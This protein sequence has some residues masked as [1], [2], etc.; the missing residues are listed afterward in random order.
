MH[1]LFDFQSLASI[2][3]IIDD[4]HLSICKNASLLSLI[5]VIKCANSK[6]YNIAY[7][8]MNSISVAVQGLKSNIF[9]YILHSSR[10]GL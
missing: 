8:L 3:K 1:F 5:K 10:S 4:S 7:F 6:G 9:R 2:L